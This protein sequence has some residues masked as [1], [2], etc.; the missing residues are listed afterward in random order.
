[1]TVEINTY[2]SLISLSYTLHQPN[3]WKNG[4]RYQNMVLSYIVSARTTG[5][6]SQQNLVFDEAASP[7]STKKNVANL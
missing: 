7:Q 2:H 1:M 4:S 3:P 6:F 5:F